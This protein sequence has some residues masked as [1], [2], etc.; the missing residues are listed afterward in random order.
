[1]TRL[2]GFVWIAALAAAAAPL[3]YFGVAVDRA[4]AQGTQAKPAPVKYLAIPAGD[5]RL[6]AAHSVIGFSIRH[7]E[8]ALV[9]G[10][11]KSVLRVAHLVE[12]FVALTNTIQNLNG[13]SFRRR[14][15]LY[16]LEA[17]FE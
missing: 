7:N 10:R 15:N 13:F 17:P 9:N 1:M 14:R 5:Y 3:I 12:A 2:K 4:K 6:D 16:R 11:F 8:L